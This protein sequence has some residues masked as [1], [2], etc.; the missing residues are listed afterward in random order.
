MGINLMYLYALQFD[1]GQLRKD[2]CVR[3]V[4]ND[5]NS[6]WPRICKVLQKRKNNVRKSVRKSTR[7]NKTSR[8]RNDKDV[9]RS[10]A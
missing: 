6:E 3:L 2:L 1:S 9:R 5:Y 10:R 4:K 8:K 7:T